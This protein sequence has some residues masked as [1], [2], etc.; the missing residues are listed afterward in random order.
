[1]GDAKELFQEANALFID[2]DYESALE[3]YNA[4]I[5]AGGSNSD[6]YVK[7]S[8][9]H[10]KLGSFTEAL[11]DANRAL[12]LDNGNTSAS[13]QA[14]FRK[15]CVLSVAFRI[16]C[17]GGPRAAWRGRVVF[18]LVR[19]VAWGVRPRWL[20][21]ASLTPAVLCLCSTCLLRR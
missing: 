20:A 3:N 10:A 19:R 11:E 13:E 14:W 12:E 1:M 2:E 16:V 21:D 15:G 5:A 4:A 17:A 6:Y 8:A 18:A 9:T 7:R